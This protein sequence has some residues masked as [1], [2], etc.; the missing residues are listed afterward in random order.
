MEPNGKIL[1]NKAFLIWD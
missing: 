1:L